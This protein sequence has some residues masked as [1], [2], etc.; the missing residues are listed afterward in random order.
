M[1]EFTAE[2]IE[3]AE[4]L[5]QHIPGAAPKALSRA[6]NR[7]V[8][9]AKTEASRKAR[10]TYHVKHKDV[11]DTINVSK[12]SPSNL[13]AMVLS[14]GHVLAL[15]KFQVRAGKPQPARAAAMR[16]DKGRPFKIVV[17][18]KRGDGGPI[19]KAFVAQMKSGHLGVFHRVNKKRLPLVQRFGPSV[20]EMLG[21]IKVTDAVDRRAEAVMDERLDHE[22]RRILEGQT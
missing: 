10:E 19:K 5:L 7:A 13:Q 3:K 20:P 9:S 21:N 22:I 6:M 1:I 12:S 11:L 15:T 14:R 16:W 2:Q 18:V 17:R 8:D 4:R